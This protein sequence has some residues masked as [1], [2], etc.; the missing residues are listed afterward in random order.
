M[1]PAE[2][3]TF[4]RAT[5]Q[6]AH[7]VPITASAAALRRHT[8]PEESRVFLAEGGLPEGEP[9]NLDF[10]LT[11]Q[12][13]TIAEVADQQDVKTGIPDEC[14]P[15][16]CVAWQYGRVLTLDPRL[17]AAVRSLDLTGEH[18]PLF[19]NSRVELLGAGLAYYVALS[20]DSEPALSDAERQA[21]LT[22]HLSRVDPVALQRQDGWWP[23][24]VEV[25]GYGFA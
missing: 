5:F 15:W 20:P 16:P 7:I 10:S 11:S 13:P 9:F 2:L 14:W 1:R 8:L 24:V 6:G 3:N 22:E 19:V 18:E 17:D 25:I 21:R 12:L 23:S 4:V